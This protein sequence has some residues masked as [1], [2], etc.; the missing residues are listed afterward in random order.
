[1]DNNN[2][3][4]IARENLR[5]IASIMESD[6]IA[7]HQI[8]EASNACLNLLK[9]ICVLQASANNSIDT[10]EQIVDKK[11]DIVNPV[12]PIERQT[13]VKTE[14]PTPKLV[15]SINQRFQVQSVLFK[16]N[17]SEMNE[18]IASFE[19]SGSNDDALMLLQDYMLRNNWKNDEPLIAVI[20]EAI[21]KM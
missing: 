2:A 15:F 13:E 12:S 8:E 1:M 3:L 9:S 19:K 17:Q 10:S 6:S 11:Q 16:G 7:T 21:K 20:R 5:K 18:F 14:K 4:V